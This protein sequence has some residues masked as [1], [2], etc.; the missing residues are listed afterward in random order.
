MN[1]STKSSKL[2]NGFSFEES[3]TRLKRDIKFNHNFRDQSFLKGGNTIP[4]V[5]KLVDYE[6]RND[7][8][9]EVYE[10]IEFMAKECFKSNAEDEYKFKLVLKEINFYLKNYENINENSNYGSD[11]DSDEDFQT[12]TIAKDLKLAIEEKLNLGNKLNEVERSLIA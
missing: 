5:T 4:L 9:M 6:V 1:K 2:L 3:K 12:I 7:N 8:I 10:R 11:Y